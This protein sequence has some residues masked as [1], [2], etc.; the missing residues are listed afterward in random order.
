[1]MYTGVSA[2]IGVS[3]SPLAGGHMVPDQVYFA[4]RAEAEAQAALKCSNEGARKAHLEL[5]ARYDELAASI[6]AHH[7]KLG[8]DEDRF[9]C[10]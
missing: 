3:R 6:A 10:G 2:A 4:S 7:N 5:A 1:M 9:S 8:T